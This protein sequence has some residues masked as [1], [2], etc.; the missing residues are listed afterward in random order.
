[1]PDDSP[2]LDVAAFY[3]QHVESEWERLDRDFHHRLEWEHT[4]E[5]LEN[6]LPET[7]HVLDVGGGA[8]RYAIWLA[9]RGHEVT[10]VDL[11]KGQVRFAR[12]KV[13]E[14]GVSDRVSVLSGDV[15]DLPVAD[16]AGAAT[17][18]LGG[19]LSHVLDVAKRRRAV[20]ELRR[21]TDPGGPVFVSVMGRL[22]AVTRMLRHLGRHPVAD[23]EAV[24]V[25][26]IARTGDYDEALLDRYDLDPTAQQ[27]HLFRAGEFENL[28]ET[29]GL[30]VTTLAAL[31]GL[32]SQRRAEQES[33]TDEHRAIVREVG[34]AL[35]EDRSVV[36]HSE[37]MLAVCRA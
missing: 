7:G 5:Y 14:H 13:A 24:L 34:R 2:P 23:E 1:M 30:S 37:H 18:C 25:P 9:E 8:G 33:L 27:M 29:E 11:S 31:E 12:E 16:D 15:R 32:F 19:P 21:V 22:A 20:R 17:C 4:V 10:L 6:H 26:H 3:D 35:R 28:L 36:D